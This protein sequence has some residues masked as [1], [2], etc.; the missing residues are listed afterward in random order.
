[1]MLAQ[2]A[3]AYRRVGEQIVAG[4]RVL[5]SKFRAAKI[6]SGERPNWFCGCRAPEGSDALRRQWPL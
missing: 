1:M 2:C 5:A 4:V 6:C 3:E